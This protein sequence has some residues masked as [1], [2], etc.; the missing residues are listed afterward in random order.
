MNE[1]VQREKRRNREQYTST[2]SSKKKFQIKT[3]Q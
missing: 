3:K 1:N 2:G